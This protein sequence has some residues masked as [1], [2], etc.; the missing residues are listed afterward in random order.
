MDIVDRLF[1]GL[2]VF[3]G[4]HFGLLAGLENYVNFYLGS[5]CA[6]VLF[7]W[8]FTRGYKI[9]NSGGNVE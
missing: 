9:L 5:V 3:I 2:V 1:W 6:F 8:F 7:I 4:I